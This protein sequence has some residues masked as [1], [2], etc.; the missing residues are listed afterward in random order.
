[1]G[2]VTN[3][4]GSVM[5]SNANDELIRAVVALGDADAYVDDL[6]Y[7]S[8]GCCVCVRTTRTSRLKPSLP[9]WR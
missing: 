7:V 8:A 2:I 1:M 4:I 3:G 9:I 6:V 5:G